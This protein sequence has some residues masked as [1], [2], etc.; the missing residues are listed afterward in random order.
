MKFSNKLIAVCFVCITGLYSFCAEAGKVHSV[1]TT[2]KVVQIFG[3]PFTAYSNFGINNIFEYQSVG[4]HSQLT[5][6]K[7]QSVK[8]AQIFM[9]D[10][11]FLFKS[12]FEARRVDYLGQ[13]SKSIECSKNFKPKYFAVDIP[14]GRLAYFNGYAGINRVAGVCAADLIKY[15]HIYGLAICRSPS[16]IIEIEHFTDV[17]R[18]IADDFISRVTCADL[19][20]FEKK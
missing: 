6:V 2:A 17:S 11:L 18:K 9:E 8:D 10:R 19:S 7:F 14:D 15:R 5:I 20:L 13:Y 4:V 1:D 12:V 3:Y 16:Y